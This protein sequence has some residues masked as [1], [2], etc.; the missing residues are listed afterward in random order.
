MCNSR[1]PGRVSLSSIRIGDEVFD[2]AIN[3]WVVVGEIYH[4]QGLYRPRLM[5]EYRN[6]NDITDV[7]SPTFDNLW[8]RMVKLS[9]KKHVIY[10][11]QY[12]FKDFFYWWQNTSGKVSIKESLMQY[13][14]EQERE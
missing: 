3:A 2:K 13:I 8:E 11:E 7:T 9:E 5:R 14:S 10:A 6:I 4:D 1:N 12:G